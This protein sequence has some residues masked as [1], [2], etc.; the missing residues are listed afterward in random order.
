[1]VRTIS[2]DALDVI[3]TGANY[4]TS[5]TVTIP[6]EEPVQVEHSPGWSV[7]DKSILAGTR[8]SISEIRLL[9]S[10]AIDDLFEFAGFPGA[11]YDLTIGINL[12]STIEQIPVFHGY[13]VEGTTR[14]N[15]LGVSVSL[16]DPWAWANDVA[17]IDPFATDLLSRA[18]QIANIFTDVFGDNLEVISTASGG[19]CCQPAIYTNT[20]GE[21]VSQLA[22]DGLLL[23][24]FNADGALFIKAQPNLTGNMTPDWSFRSDQDAGLIAPA[25]PAEPATIIAGTLERTRPWAESTYNRVKVIPGGDWQ[26]WSAQTARL[27]DES[28]PRHEDYIGVRELRI[29]SNSLGSAY[30]A[31]QL[32]L[33]ELTRR[34]RVTDERVRLSVALNPAVEADDV[35]YVA[36]LPTLDDSGWNGTYIVT[37]VTHAPS[38]AATHIEA[39]SA[40]GY[41]LGT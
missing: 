33:S 38:E 26:L 5:L 22:N 9:P 25:A 8:L 15:S 18:T 35:I 27:T 13:A 31:Y 29:T 7:N 11:V 36:A 21:A 19:S 20:R 14:R 23:V 10:D 17:F 30:G 40:T 41:S 32:A 34:L 28:D 3:G 1:M 4:S 37:S 12:G 16:T 39:V 2:A 24:G 6:G